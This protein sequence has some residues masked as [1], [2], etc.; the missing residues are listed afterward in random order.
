MGPVEE[1]NII[2]TEVEDTVQAITANSRQ[3]RLLKFI[4]ERCF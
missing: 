1:M 4:Q 3:S 2:I